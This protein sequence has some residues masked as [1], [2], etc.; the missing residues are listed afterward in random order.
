M[1]AKINVVKI[2]SD[3]GKDKDVLTKN[4]QTYEFVDKKPTTKIMSEG[5]STSTIGRIAGTILIAV[6]TFSLSAILIGFTIF[7]FKIWGL[8]K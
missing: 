4:T 6:L 1:S 8:I 2:E 7:L 5:N 3:H